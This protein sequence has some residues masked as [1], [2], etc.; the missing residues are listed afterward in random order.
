MADYNELQRTAGFKAIPGTLAADTPAESLEG[1]RGFLMDLV[2]I[3]NP[4]PTTPEDA[5]LAA[6]GG[7]VGKLGGAML[8][9]M[10]KYV[11][12]EKAGTRLGGMIP[13]GDELKA[14]MERI[15]KA[16][17][18]DPE[19]RERAR[20]TV[21]SPSGKLEVAN[22]VG[23]DVS[24]YMPR[25]RSEVIA[26]NRPL[27]LPTNA[28][29]T[30]PAG[31]SGVFSQTDVN[32]IGRSGADGLTRGNIEH[33]VATPNGEYTWLTMPKGVPQSQVFGPRP[34][35]ENTNDNAM[36]SLARLIY[37]AKK[38]RWDLQLGFNPLDYGVKP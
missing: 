9:G 17:G 15:M 24:V 26:R 33:V 30:H 18:K 34:A 8:G 22:E 36:D 14:G 7:P 21:V 38:D 27:E 3:L 1:G 2:N 16:T 4:I 5:A 37:G 13:Y 28:F 23:D 19:M 29:H 12:W 11:P 25:T 31:S 10:L 35:L 32:L 6:V 20:K